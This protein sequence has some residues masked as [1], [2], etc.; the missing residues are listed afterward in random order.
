M[1]V[2]TTGVST[3][4]DE[5]T[6]DE[7]EGGKKDPESRLYVDYSGVV[8]QNG[9]PSGSA[10]IQHELRFPGQLDPCKEKEIDSIIVITSQARIYIYV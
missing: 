9:S 8:D 10:L 7:D 2:P 6:N 1:Y 4:I 3:A 5:E